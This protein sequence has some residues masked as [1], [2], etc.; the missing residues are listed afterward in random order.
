M[1]LLQPDTARIGHPPGKPA[2]DR[3]PEEL[4]SGTPRELREALSKLI[5]ARPGSAPRY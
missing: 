4:V 5:G 1:A 3:V 2:E